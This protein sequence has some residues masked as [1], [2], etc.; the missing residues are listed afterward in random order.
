MEFL[1]NS[2]ASINRCLFSTLVAANNWYSKNR[3]LSVSLLLNILL[4]ISFFLYLGYFG[5]LGLGNFE[6]P[7]LCGLKYYLPELYK[8]V[9]SVKLLDR[10][11][12]SGPALELGTNPS[13]GLGLRSEA[14]SLN[15]YIDNDNDLEKSDTPEKLRS[16][17]RDAIVL[18]VIAIG[19]TFY[20]LDLDIWYY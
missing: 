11:P 3:L 18:L 9:D 10:G 6:I 7:I 5:P 15:S 20:S 14:E 4:G 12:A 1:S 19:L 17:R 13:L 2:Y 16:R 8:P